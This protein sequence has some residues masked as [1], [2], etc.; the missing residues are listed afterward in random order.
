VEFCVDTMISWEKTQPSTLMAFNLTWRSGCRVL[1]DDRRLPRPRGRGAPLHGTVVSGTCQ[2]W[3]LVA[4]TRN[5]VSSYRCTPPRTRT[6]RHRI[7][8]SFSG[9]SRSLSGHLRGVG[10]GESHV[11]STTYAGQRELTCTEYASAAGSAASVP[12]LARVI[13]LNGDAALN[14][15]GRTA[16]RHI[17]W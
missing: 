9:R 7:H 10:S 2:M 4:A 16:S 6:T 12:Y 11:E 13:G 5:R 14:G 1:S 17:G 8:P 3:S 15:P